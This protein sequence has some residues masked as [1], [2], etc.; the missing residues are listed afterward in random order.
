MT[1][2]FKFSEDDKTFNLSM[3]HEGLNQIN[4]LLKTRH[5]SRISPHGVRSKYVCIPNKVIQAGN[6]ILNEVGQ[7]EEVNVPPRIGLLHHYREKCVLSK[8]QDYK[9]CL[10]EPS[11]VDRTAH[12]FKDKLLQGINEAFKRLSKHCYLA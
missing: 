3:E 9:S 8:E 2:Y 1:F 6:H 7:G 11:T 5:R 12:K 10:N 4:V